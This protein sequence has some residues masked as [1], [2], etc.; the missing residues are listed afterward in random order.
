MN[1]NVALNVVELT[2]T[3][4]LLI[5]M[6]NQCHSGLFIVYSELIQYTIQ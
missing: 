3:T 1:L 2:I 5:T 4:K 6:N